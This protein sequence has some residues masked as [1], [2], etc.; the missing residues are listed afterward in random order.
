MKPIRQK[1][2]N[3][4]NAIKMRC[5]FCNNNNQKD[6]GGYFKNKFVCRKCER[7]WDILESIVE[8]NA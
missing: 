1:T 6:E 7:D 5:A 3:E 4:M 8:Q 2:I